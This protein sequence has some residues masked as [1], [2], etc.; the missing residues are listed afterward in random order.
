MDL[1]FAAKKQGP[2]IIEETIGQF[3]AII[4]KLER[5]T[6]DCNERVNENQATITRLEEQNKMFEEAAAKAQNVIK[7]I[8]SI[9]NGGHPVEE[10][11]EDA[12][13]DEDS[14]STDEG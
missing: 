6:D 9:L 14:G 5:G 3:T 7:G 2:E 12:G 8:E 13:N 11:N 1:P 4:S 10:P